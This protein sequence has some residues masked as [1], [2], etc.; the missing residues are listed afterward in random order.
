MYCA[1]IPRTS[2]CLASQQSTKTSGSQRASS[3]C[4][5]NPCLLCAIQTLNASYR[6]RGRAWSLPWSVDSSV[7][8]S[9]SILFQSSSREF[10]CRSKSPPHQ[11]RTKAIRCQDWS[12]TLSQ[13]HCCK[14][15]LLRLLATGTWAQNLL[16][17]PMLKT[18][19]CQ[20]LALVENDSS[21]RSPS[22]FERPRVLGFVGRSRL[23][24]SFRLCLGHLAQL[25]LEKQ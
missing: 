19:W 10:L 21:N 23:V 13:F 25:G 16:P 20:T 11:H 8:A 22:V 17:A 14:H 5:T 7:P 3:W 6:R 1:H 12:R 15:R 9:E 4:Y 2:N 24:W 18:S